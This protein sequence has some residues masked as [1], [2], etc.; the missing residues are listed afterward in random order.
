MNR[1]FL[2]TGA[3]FGLLAVIIGAFGAHGLKPL[4]DEAARESFET[5]VKYQMYHA[6]LFLL[7]GSFNFTKFR[8][9]KSIF[10]LLL[11]GVICF[12]GSIYLLAT[13][14]LTPIDF[15]G[16][17]LVTPLGGTLLIAAWIFLL[18]EFIKIKAK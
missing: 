10:F 16:I 6:L 7:V 12:S 3:I 1:K 14:N 11:F 15:T 18:V 17:A 13:N 4:L 9:Q 5:G 2:I 8:F